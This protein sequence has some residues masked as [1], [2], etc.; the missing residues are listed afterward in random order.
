MNTW[1]VYPLKR[2]CHVDSSGVW[3]AEPDACSDPTPVCTTAHI[4]SEG[5]F[6]VDS[7]P[8]RCLSAEE[9]DRYVCRS[10]DLIVVKASGSADNVVSGKCGLVRNDEQRF[11]FGNF[12]MRLRPRTNIV[13]S[14]FLYH[15]VTSAEMRESIKV[16]VLTTTYPNLQLGEYLNFKAR[17]PDLGMQDLILDALE[18]K[19]REI[20]L[21]LSNRR[22]LVTALQEQKRAIFSRAVTRGINPDAPMKHS[23]LDWLG[24]MPAHWESRRAKYYFNEIDERSEWR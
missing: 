14:A 2:L 17:V 9:L 7:M 1:R 11:A 10:G 22:R 5:N 23:G 3:G 8:R 6:D 16:A 24:E 12:L 20:T 19:L 4:S 15:V 13:R 18:V 21:L